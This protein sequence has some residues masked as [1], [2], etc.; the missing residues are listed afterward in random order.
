MTHASLA[1]GAAELQVVPTPAISEIQAGIAAATRAAGQSSSTADARTPAM[2]RSISHQP[3]PQRSPALAA[4]ICTASAGSL[5]QHIRKRM[6][7]ASGNL[8]RAPHNKGRR[9]CQSRQILAWL[10]VHLR[11]CCMLLT[12][13]VT[14]HR[15]SHCSWLN[16][17]HI[18]LQD[19]SQ[20]TVTVLE[21]LQEYRLI[22]GAKFVFVCRFQCRFL[23]VWRA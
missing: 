4:D 6:S 18:W 2:G 5:I 16:T 9:I 11:V 7:H 23:G 21:I 14:Q 17:M 19:N 15:G 13:C 12:V 3:S 10:R 1:G 20:Q 22:L 8:Q